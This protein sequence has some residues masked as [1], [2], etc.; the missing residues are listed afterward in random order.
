MY[1]KNIWKILSNKSIIVSIVQALIQ[2]AVGPP[3]HLQ[4]KEEDKRK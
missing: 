1:E 4:K 2:G 3:H